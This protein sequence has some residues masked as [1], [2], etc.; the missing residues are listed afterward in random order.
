MPRYGSLRMKIS[1]SLTSPANVSA[2]LFIAY[3]RAPIRTGM[4]AVWATRRS[5]LS[6]MAVTKSRASE[7]IGERE[8][9]NMVCPISLLIASR[10]LPIT[11]T[12]IG[13]I[14]LILTSVSIR[15]TLCLS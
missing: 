5:S 3:G 4:Y 13:S 2:I 14:M 10:R 7:K 15:L 6:K 11:E 9:R 1:P 12:L 8:V